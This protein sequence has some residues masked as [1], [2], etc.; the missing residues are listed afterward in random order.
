MYKSTISGIKGHLI[1]AGVLAY[2][3]VTYLFYMTMGMYNELFLVYS[4][5]IGLSF[6]ALVKVIFSFNLQTINAHIEY[7]QLLRLAAVFLIINSLLIGFMW[8]NIIVPPLWNGTIYP[9]SLE[10]YTTLIV[11]WF[12]LGLLLPLA[13]VSGYLSLKRKNLGYLST[14]VYMVFLSVL[15]IY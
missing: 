11:Q 1:L 13:F 5:L 12:D 8:L 14:I 6:F 15:F 7:N 2:F 4:S 9:E 3:L 10:H